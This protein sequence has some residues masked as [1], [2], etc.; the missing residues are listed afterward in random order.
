MYG[1]SLGK[2]QQEG[3]SRWK[4]CFS[5][6]PRDS[7]DWSIS[8]LPAC[9]MVETSSP[10]YL[11]SNFMVRLDQSSVRNIAGTSLWGHPSS[12]GLP[13]SQRD[14][15][16]QSMWDDQNQ[17][18]ESRAVLDFDWLPS[19]Q[20]H[21]SGQSPTP[22]SDIPATGKMGT[23]AAVHPTLPIHLMLPSQSQ[24]RRSGG[25]FQVSTSSS[26]PS[27]RAFFSAKR[28][29]LSNLSLSR[30]SSREEGGHG[31]AKELIEADITTPWAGWGHLDIL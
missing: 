23:W 18:L 28:S 30:F 3:S 22:A 7:N 15:K 17:L 16:G 26:L 9:A 10:V 6:T 29:A 2:H 1:Q 5:C 4:L 20:A 13:K 27:K 25:T 11:P 24:A 14:P 8:S 12:S 19:G 31:G 21:I